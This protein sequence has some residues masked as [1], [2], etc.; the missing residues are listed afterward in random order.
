MLLHGDHMSTYSTTM[1]FN[2]CA[3]QWNIPTASHLQDSEQDIERDMHKVKY[4][5][6]AATERR[7]RSLLKNGS[8]SHIAV[9]SP[10]KL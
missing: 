9:T 8:M 4:G 2:V 1:V 6:R 7:P 3:V 10:K 5:N